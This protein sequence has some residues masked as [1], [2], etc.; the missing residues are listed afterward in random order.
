MKDYL[1][2]VHSVNGRLLNIISLFNSPFMMNINRD[3]IL[4][5]SFND[6][7]NISHPTDDKFVESLEKVTFEEDSEIT[8]GICLEEFKKDDEA[9]ILPCKDQKHYF[10][11]GNDKE[12]CEGILPWL[13]E[14]NSCPICREKIS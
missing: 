12:T 14:N 9:F 10:H 6:Q 2:W 7:G 5:R 13:K 11:V 4:N 1:I 8:C 3:N